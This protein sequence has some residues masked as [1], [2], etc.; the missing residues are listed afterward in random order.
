MKKKKKHFRDKGKWV[1]K[2]VGEQRPVW[3][4]RKVGLKKGG[5]KEDLG[6]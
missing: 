4:K 1:G 2:K 6:V 5:K 3:L